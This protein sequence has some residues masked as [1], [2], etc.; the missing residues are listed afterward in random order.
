VEVVSLYKCVYFFG[1]L[2][3]VNG[4]YCLTFIGLNDYFAFSVTSLL[5]SCLMTY[6]F[7]RRGL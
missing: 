5:F 3:G 4:Y 6:G 7:F 2:F 1:V